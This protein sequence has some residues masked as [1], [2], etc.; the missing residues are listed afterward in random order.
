MV[1]VYMARENLEIVRVQFFAKKS[2]PIIPEFALAIYTRLKLCYTVQ[3]PLW[4]RSAHSHTQSYSNVLGPYVAVGVHMTRGNVETIEVQLF[5]K[6]LKLIYSLIRLG[7]LYKLAPLLYCTVASTEAL[8]TQQHVFVQ[9][10]SG[11]MYCGA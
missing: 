1:R 4:R 10:C 6:K 11:D 5:R 9:Y 8:G 7:H 2:S 3:S